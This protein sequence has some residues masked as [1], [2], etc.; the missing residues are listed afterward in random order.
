MATLAENA[1][2]VKAAQVAIDAAIVAK[3]G[4]TDGG[5]MHAAAAIVSIPSGGA[6]KDMLEELYLK[7]LKVF[8]ISD[9]NIPNNT[10]STF[11]S[12]GARMFLGYQSLTHFIAPQLNIDN[13][14]DFQD[15][16]SLTTVKCWDFSD[17][18]Y[19]HFYRTV[20]LRDIIVVGKTSSE[21]IT[22]TAQLAVMPNTTLVITCS[23]GKF[24]RYIDG[25]WVIS[26]TKE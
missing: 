12:Y 15:C 23:D 24:V 10:S 22:K 11:S 3:G 9:L 5:L 13:T 25:A 21:V 16:K 6:Y 18:K 26:E 7:T 4:T 20:N 1:A 8:D 17:A 2:A 19:S 14:Y